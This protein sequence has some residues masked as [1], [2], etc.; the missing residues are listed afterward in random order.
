MQIIGLIGYV[1]KYD[2]VINLAKSIN[3]MNKSVL[4]IDAT[5]DQKLKSVIPALDNIGRDYITQYNNIDFA[6]GFQSLH[7]IENYTADMGINISL[8]DFILIDIDSEKTYEFFRTRGF[9][10]TYFFIDT[11]V[12]SVQKNKEIIK[13]MRLYNKNEPIKLRKVFF[14]SFASRAAEKY[15]EE[16]VNDYNVE[17]CEPEYELAM[18]DI[19]KIVNIDSQFS[20][21]IDL[22][23]HS[24]IYNN[25]LAD[26]SSEI[27]DDVTT[28]E[29]LRQIKRRRD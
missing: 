17:W 22:R 24:K 21:L 29:V 12:L 28:R 15:F 19:D 25:T 8:Y 1:D 10:K 5:N 23:R 27:I 20:G 18:D 6:V 11:S 3:I 26:I 7:D 4:V 14:K 2:F 16:Q 9:D 13:S